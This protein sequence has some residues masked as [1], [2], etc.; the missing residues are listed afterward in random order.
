MFEQVAVLMCTGAYG[1]A[2]CPDT[3][4]VQKCGH[5]FLWSVRESKHH[6]MVF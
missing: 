4:V 3:C 6:A 1:T 5:L 2:T